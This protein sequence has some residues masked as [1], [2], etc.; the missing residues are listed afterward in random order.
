[1]DH[2]SDVIISTVFAT[3]KDDIARHQA[4]HAAV[5]AGEQNLHHQNLN[6]L[7]DLIKKAHVL[8]LPIKILPEMPVKKPRG[9]PQL[10]LQF[11]LSFILLFSALYNHSNRLNN[12]KDC[13]LAV[14]KVY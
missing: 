8:D 14:N 11:K 10:V 12:Y 5:E 7:K 6:D 9:K 13:K 1:M 3:G 4:H 2:A